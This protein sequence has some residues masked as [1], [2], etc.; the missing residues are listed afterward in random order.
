MMGGQILITPRSLTALGVETSEALAPLR[1]AGLTLVSGPI[2]RQPTHIELLDLVPGCVGWIAGVERIDASI[3]EAATDLRV[4]SRYGVGTD[5]VDLAAARRHNII[6]ERTVGANADSVAELALL[7]IL[8][9][10]R[11]V[12]PSA[13]A[14]AEGRWERSEGHELP[15]SVVGIIGLGAVGSAVARLV[16]ALGGTADGHDP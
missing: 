2:G 10:L 13:R 9:G 12:T 6:V 3:L 14:L 15:E 8:S 7:H 11:Q 1:A 16:T 5:A 4:I